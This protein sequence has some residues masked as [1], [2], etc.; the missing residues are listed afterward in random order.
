MSSPQQYQPIAKSGIRRKIG[1]FTSEAMN[2][3]DH[4]LKISLALT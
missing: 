2:E 3:I 1:S 4:C